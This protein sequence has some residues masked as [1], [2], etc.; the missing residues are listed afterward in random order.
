VTAISRQPNFANTQLNGNLNNR[1]NK[2]S[3]NDS[4]DQ[5]LEPRENAVEKSP[6]NLEEETD[7]QLLKRIIL[8]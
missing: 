3:Q 8:D 1:A 2:P 5:L 7:E 4:F 6:E